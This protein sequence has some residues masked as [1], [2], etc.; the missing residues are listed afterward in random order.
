MLFKDRFSVGLTLV[1][2]MFVSLAVVA[3]SSAQS[4]AGLA[5]VTGV[6]G[7]PQVQKAGA[8]AYV[9][10]NSGDVINPGDRIKTDAKSKVTLL[11]N[12]GEIRMISTKADVAMVEKSQE[13]TQQGIATLARAAIAPEA[14]DVMSVVTGARAKLKGGAKE[15]ASSLGGSVGDAGGAQPAAQAPAENAGRLAAEASGKA[16]AEVVPPPAPTSPPADINKSAGDW[17]DGLAQELEETRKKAD[18]QKT[19]KVNF[20]SEPARDKKTSDKTE[21]IS[22]E[23][24]AVLAWLSDADSVAWADIV[25][26]G[27]DTASV[28]CIEIS[29]G[30]KVVAKAGTLTESMRF[31]N[32]LK[33]GSGSFKASLV[34]KNGERRE[35]AKFNFNTKTNEKARASL[36]ANSLS[37]LDNPDNRDT[38]LFLKARILEKH[39][40]RIAALG[41]LS[42]IEKLHPGKPLPHVSRTKILIYNSLGLFNR[43]VE[44]SEKSG[45]SASA[46]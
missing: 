11:F 16:G 6:R 34:F 28:K 33:N 29:A 7:T 30:S 14:D 38:F 44:E 17:Q 42:E 39:G 37:G 19:R 9:P 45:L 24:P 21:E 5:T 26:G 35:L 46:K 43:V 18:E 23:K 32:L 25:D 36:E 22:A 20:R 3:A 31:D 10:L 13:K 2:L 4:P 41:C 27:V 12:D 15:E 8:A 1:F 40:F